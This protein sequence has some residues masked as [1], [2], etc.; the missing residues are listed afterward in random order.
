MSAAGTVAVALDRAA[1]L[2]AP[3]AG[4]D[5]RLEAEVLLA[6]ALGIDRAH[7][8]ARLRDL[9]SPDETAAFDALLGRRTN[10]EP[11][12]YVTGHREFYAIDFAVTP[13]VLI[14]RP[15][16]EM[17]VE[18]A[19]RAI[20]ARDG[21]ALVVDVGTGSGAIA[22]AIALHAPG[23]RIIATDAS[24]A[25]L[26]VAERNAGA[27]GVAP[28]IEF[29]QADLLEGVPL[30]DIIVANLPYVAESD[31]AALPPELRDS[32]PRDALV[33]GTDGTAVI[34][35][36]LDQAPAHLQPGGVLIAE[37]GDRQGAALLA[38]ARRRFPAAG[39]YIERDFAGLDRMLVVEMLG[40]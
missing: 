35:R 11:L 9:L 12:A 29:R 22:V 30:V 1:R 18:R 7:V 21:R 28:R 39:C 6:H 27:A 33:G 2:L 26:A 37:I 23:A 13:E 40:G 17:L 32:E 10:R 36:F 20:A 14:P 25:A 8:T 24:P 4:D 19:L 31:W 16:T 38:A 3:F 5:A 15:E 34:R